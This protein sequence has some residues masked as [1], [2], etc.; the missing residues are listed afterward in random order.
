MAE[1]TREQEFDRWWRAGH[2]AMRSVGSDPYSAEQIWN[3]AW[4]MA[5]RACDEQSGTPPQEDTITVLMRFYGVKSIEALV[6]AQA[7]HIVRLQAK[8]PKYRDAFPRTPREG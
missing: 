2:L 5:L 4:D 7:D 3:A 1:L 8:L 6:E